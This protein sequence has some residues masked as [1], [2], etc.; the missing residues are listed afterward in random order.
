M[1]QNINRNTL[2]KVFKA[3]G[4]LLNCS[5]MVVVS[6]DVAPMG[7][8]MAQSSLGTMQDLKWGTKPQKIRENT[9]VVGV[10]LS[11]ELES[12]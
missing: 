7:A 10:V 4:L 12:G 9:L 1:F 11:D 3:S 8:S 6:V 2:V 5:P